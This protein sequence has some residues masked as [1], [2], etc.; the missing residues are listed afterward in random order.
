MDATERYKLNKHMKANASKESRITGP[1]N[2]MV[3]QTIQYNKKLSIEPDIRT[4]MISI[5][6]QKQSPLIE[7]KNY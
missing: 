1:V 4:M 2:N 5:T 3:E 7:E 6:G